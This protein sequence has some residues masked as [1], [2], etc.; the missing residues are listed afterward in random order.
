MPY[1]FCVVGCRRWAPLVLALR[2]GAPGAL[3]TGSGHSQQGADGWA[4]LLKGVVPRAG[5]R[6]GVLGVPSWWL[7]SDA[8]DGVDAVGV[9]GAAA[10]GGQDGDA[11]GDGGDEGAFGSVGE[12]VPTL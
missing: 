2:E 12:D 3:G 8:P 5:A 4:S 9:P 1:W 10:C 6:R 11:V 7:G